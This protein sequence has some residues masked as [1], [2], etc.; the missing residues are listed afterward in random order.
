MLTSYFLVG[1]SVAL[2]TRAINAP[3]AKMSK[4]P[5]LFL[6][7][8]SFDVSCLCAWLTSFFCGRA[9]DM[10]QFS[11]QYTVAAAASNEF[12]SL[13]RYT[14]GRVSDTS[15]HNHTRPC[16]WPHGHGVNEFLR[17]FP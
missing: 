17:H 6:V 16:P 2:T 15:L 3:I 5:V 7:L 11:T 9:S 10:L 1:L 14:R 12:A 4:V 13:F 8:F